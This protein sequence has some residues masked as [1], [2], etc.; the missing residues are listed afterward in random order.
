MTPSNNLSSVLIVFQTIGGAFFVSA[1]QSAFI[2]FVINTLPRNAPSV[3]AAK[4]V[5]TGVTELRS[6]FPPDVI[7][8]LL[9]SY[10]SGLHAAFA[11]AL[12]SAGIATILG[13]FSKWRTI[14][15]VE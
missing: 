10:L 6:V 15:V 3:D 13:F 7:P 8:G 1:S 11:L 12:V 2:N 9:R 4:V 5:A 14:K